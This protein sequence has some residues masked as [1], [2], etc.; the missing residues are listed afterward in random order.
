[1]SEVGDAFCQGGRVLPTPEQ[2][3]EARRI[4]REIAKVGF[5]LPGTLSERYLTCTHVGCHCHADPP[6]LHG[7]YWYWTRKVH[8][9][10][11]SRSLSRE[12]AAEYQPW[13]ENE[14]R[15]RLLV[16]ELEELS[17]SI[18]EADPRSP[19]RR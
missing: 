9:K 14:K 12:Q 1:M 4:G 17:M 2:R 8:A 19:K 7:P 3:A 16:H 18:L 15:L 13:F 6:N 11:V 10:T 5:A